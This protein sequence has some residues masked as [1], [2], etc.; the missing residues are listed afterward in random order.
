MAKNISDR[1]QESLVIDI[2]NW[3]IILTILA[4]RMIF[5]FL[6]ISKSGH[7]RLASVVFR[8]LCFQQFC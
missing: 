4:D 5:Q 1:F 8:G 6:I 2:W 7:E 3:I